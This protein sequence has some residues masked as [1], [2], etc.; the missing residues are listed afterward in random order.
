MPH[1][2]QV[3]LNRDAIT[4]ATVVQPKLLG[5][6]KLRRPRLEVRYRYSWIVGDPVPHLFELD[7][8]DR[9]TEVLNGARR[10][11]KRSARQLVQDALD[12]GERERGRYT[13]ALEQLSFPRSH[14]YT[15]DP[16]ERDEALMAGLEGLGIDV[17]A[18]FLTTLDLAVRVETGPEDYEIGP[19]TEEWGRREQIRRV[20]EAINAGRGGGER[21]FC[22]YAEDLPGW[23]ECFEPLWL[24]LSQEEDERLRELGI[25]AAKAADENS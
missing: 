2:Q 24:W 10:S 5:L 7:S 19:G 8:P 1:P 17:P 22:E 13:G 21:R 9:W 23:P 16:T 20:C 6:F 25:V 3:T 11:Q 14:W 18:N 15:E 4:D 12:D